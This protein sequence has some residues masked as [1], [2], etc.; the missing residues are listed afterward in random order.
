MVRAGGVVNFF[1]GCPKE[2]AICLDTGRIHYGSLT[3]RATFHHT[4]GHI[5]E[6]LD[7]ICRGDVHASDFILD[8]APLSDLIAVFQS[9][10]SRNGR[11]KTAWTRRKKRCLK[12]P[13]DRR[14]K[15]MSSAAAYFRILAILFFTAAGA[16][17]AQN[18][19]EAA[20]ILFDE[21]GGRLDALFAGV[22]PNEEAE[23]AFLQ[24][25]RLSEACR[26]PASRC[27]PEASLC[28]RR[29]GEAPY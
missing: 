19:N 14:N 23:A 15:I 18:G 2:T 28:G 22:S 21:S 1:G 27:R 4:P 16:L 8:E 20:R 29:C 13:I 12:R 10:M 6:A 3:L 24:A 26:N 25:G 17:L 7:I 9:M 5:R 11:L